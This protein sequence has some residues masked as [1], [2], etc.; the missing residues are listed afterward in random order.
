MITINRAISRRAP[1]R[2]S[3]PQH[4]RVGFEVVARAYVYV[5]GA[6]TQLPGD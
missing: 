1:P 4:E 6:S 2:W 5:I 3:D